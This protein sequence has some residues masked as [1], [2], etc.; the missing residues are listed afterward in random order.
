MS[1]SGN[2]SLPDN[3]HYIIAIGASAGGLEAI[4]EFFDNMPSNGNLS[5][6]IIQHLSSDYKSLLV[7]LVARHTNMQVVEAKQDVTVEKNCIY[8]I[9][10]N[11]LLTIQDG[12][13]QLTE[14]NIEKAPNTAIDTFLRSLADDQGS[15]AIAVILSGTGTDGTRGIAS[16]QNAGGMVLVQDPISAKFDGMPNSAIASGNVDY[17][18]SP[19]LMPEEI[20]NYIKERPVQIATDE[21]PDESLLPEVLKLID[22]H[23][24]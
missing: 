9:P 2:N 5:F 3:E 13:L 6:V 16:I 17:I 8:V 19:E 10:N 1:H 4:H 18:L 22:K 7:E 15:K 21:K 11:K 23:C 20:F 12:R 24:N 14:K